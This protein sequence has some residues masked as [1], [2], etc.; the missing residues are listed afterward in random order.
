MA[1]TNYLLL[2]P[3]QIYYQPTTTNIIKYNFGDVA[4]LPLPLFVKE[5][6]NKIR[7]TSWMNEKPKHA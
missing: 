1:I 2:V 6:N 7:K 5:K 3:S 4:L